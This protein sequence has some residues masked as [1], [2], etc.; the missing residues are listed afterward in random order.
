MFIEDFLAYNA[1]KM[2]AQMEHLDPEF[3]GYFMCLLNPQLIQPEV[4]KH[5]SRV[6]G[7]AMHIWAQNR[8]LDGDHLKINGG[9]FLPMDKDFIKHPYSRQ[10]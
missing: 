9:S 6:M 8:Y 4:L 2:A 7:N 1:D 5:M 3:M 10:D